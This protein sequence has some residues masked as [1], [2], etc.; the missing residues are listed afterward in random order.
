MISPQNNYLLCYTRI[1]QDEK[2]YAPKLAYSMHLAYSKD[3]VHFESLNHNS[4]V[5]FAK[6]TENENRTLQAK[7]LKN[8][9]LFNMPDGSFGVIAVRIE[10]Y[11]ENDAQSKG[12]ALL[13]TSTDLL[14]YEE[15]GL[16]DLK[17]DTFLND[18]VCEYDEESKGYVI[19]WSDEKGNYYQNFLS[20]FENLNAASVPKKTEPFVLEG[21]SAEI[22]GSVPRNVI[23]VPPEVAHRL[24]C[25]LTVP[26]NVAMKVPDSIAAASEDALRAVR[27]SSVYSDGTTASKTVDWD[28]AG[29]D[30]NQSGT[31]AIS[32][33]IHSDH[34]AFPA[35]MNRA[36]P[37][38]AK[39]NGKYY[40]IATNDA[41]GNHTLYI[42]ESNTIPGLLSAEE[43][44]ILDSNTYEH[45]GNLLWAPEIHTIEDDVY[46][47][48]AASPG[49]FLHE[50]AHVMK[51][52]SGGNPMCA[53]DW[54]M[55]IRVVKK[56]GTEL[57]AAG[58]TI[59]LDMTVIKW[60]GEVY[61]SWS[62]RQFVPVDRGAW[63]YIAK[64]NPKEPWKLI[65]D[66][67]LL[68]KPDYGWANNHTYVDEGPFAL[69]RNEKL[70]LT[71][72]S[73]MIDTTYVV[74]LLTANKDADLLDP[75]SWTKGNYPI[76]TSRS[77]PGEYGPGHNAYVADDDG[78]IWNT[79]H[80]RPGIEAPRCTGIRRVHFD[81]DGYP[82]L[83]M[84]EEK[85]LNRDL[86]N[87]SM[88]V[89]VRSE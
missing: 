13:F 65:S 69:I 31:Y 47:F 16:V 42:R 38:I 44:L 73:A 23:Q 72:S 71:F 82:V 8:P 63:L 24:N 1:P 85:D 78:V 51:L 6:A 14:Q 86:K 58:K 48:H 33:T 4:G 52:R 74:G 84:T 36:D 11:G 64:V 88:N 22:E 81:I 15:K 37:C 79:Y 9:Y 89:I 56:D 21:V 3:G 20:N 17:G 34:Y 57:C 66:P 87:I 28:T 35:A 45:I 7:S 32:G 70:F 10:A 54:S 76:L 50:E 5:L 25:K 30:W 83:G 46:I 43:V 12:C 27:A 75:N 41:D 18:V 68:S 55:P 62:E 80:A 26:T 39:W 53:A 49:E 59:S 67:V 60:N 77:V 29:I 2:L 61:V 19:R 40:F